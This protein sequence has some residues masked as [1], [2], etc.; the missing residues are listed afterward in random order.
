MSNMVCIISIHGN[1]VLDL[2]LKNCILRFQ[3][4][5][6]INFNTKLIV[7]DLIRSTVITEARWMLWKICNMA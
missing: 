6:H 7:K 3:F 2:L 4:F 5:N 1:Y